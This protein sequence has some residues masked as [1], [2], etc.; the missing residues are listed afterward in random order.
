MERT[1]Y[2]KDQ[3]PVNDVIHYF[4]PTKDHASLL[5]A[6]AR[7]VFS[8]TFARLYAPIPFAQFLEEAYGPGGSME[9]DLADA[10]ICWQVA[11]IGDQPI[12]YAKL[13]RLVAPAP[14]P[15]SGAMELRQIYVLGRWHGKGVADRLISWAL[16][17]A[18]TRGAR[19]IYL[20]VFDHNS[21]AKALLRS[22]W[23]F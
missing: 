2:S 19:E 10:S 1:A 17:I 16:D 8:D 5:C 21:R 11:A 15:H 23:L 7:Q 9:R 14:D 22:P 4:V 12:G 20:T 18:H 6:M 3:K 13:S